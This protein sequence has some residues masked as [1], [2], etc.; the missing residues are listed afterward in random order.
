MAS[1]SLEQKFVDAIEAVLGRWQPM[2]KASVVAVAGNTV[3]LRFAND[4]DNVTPGVS[5]LASYTP[6]V[7]DVVQVW[8]HAGLMVVQ[9][10]IA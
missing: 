6:A 9:D 3:T 10:R 5:H 4:P 1:A 2:R 8:S 7:G